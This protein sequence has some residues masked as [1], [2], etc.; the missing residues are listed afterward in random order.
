MSKR[1]GDY[2]EVHQ[3][4]IEGAW[5]ANQ[6]IKDFPSFVDGLDSY[7][8]QSSQG[9]S[10]K[11]ILSNEDYKQLFEN[12]EN[13]SRLKANVSDEEYKEITQ[14]TDDEIVGDSSY[15]VQLK[16]KRGLKTAPRT[17]LEV[18]RTPKKV[19]FH[20]YER[21][22]KSVRGGIKGYNKWGMNEKSYIKE[23]RGQGLKPKDAI[24]QYRNRFRTS[25]KTSSSL[26]TAY[27][28]A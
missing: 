7:L 5:Y 12:P 9:E 14:K 20:S 22:G 3:R 27:Y 6:N 24:A 18:L 15:E 13:L 16:Q 19:E 17:N 23:L 4:F 25:T 21:K 28:R 8:G 1:L 11:K 10:A 26:R 2:P